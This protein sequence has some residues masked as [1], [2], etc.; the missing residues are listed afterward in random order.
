[1]LVVSV[2][3]AP[4]WTSTWSYSGPDKDVLLVYGTPTNQDLGVY[5]FRIVASDGVTA[6]AQNVQLVVA[7]DVSGNFTLSWTP[8]TENEDGSPATNLVGY[9]YYLWPPNTDTV[10]NHT[11]PGTQLIVGN[12]RSGL[13]KVAVAAIGSNGLESKLSPVLPFLVRDPGP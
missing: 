2:Q 13:W 7:A 1:P 11:L 10:V 3:N 6:A 9:R 4:R 5:D 12:P 8:P